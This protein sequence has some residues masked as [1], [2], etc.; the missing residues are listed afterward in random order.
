MDGQLIF[1]EKEFLDGNIF[2]FEQRLHSHVNKYIQGGAILS[3]YFSQQG[4]ATTV[5]RGTRDI[6]QLFGKQSPLR[7]SKIS[8]FPLYAFGPTNPDNTD[9]NQIEDITV[10]GDFI[11]LP[12]TTVPNVFDFFILNHLKMTA[13]FQ[14][15][16]VT[17]DSMKI[18][19]FYKIRY[20]LISTEDETIQKLNN[21]VVEKY[22]VDLNAVGSNLN[23]VIQEDEFIHKKQVQQMVSQM[24][25]SYRALYYNERHNCFL[26]HHPDMGLDWFDLCGNEFM[27]KHSIMNN[28]NSTKVI[29]LNSKIRDIQLS[30]FYNNSIY[31]WLELGAPARML[32]NFHFILNYADGYPY[33]SFVKWNDGDIQVMQPL[34][35]HQVGVNFREYSFF[36]ADQLAAFIDVNHEPTSYYEKLIW[37]YIHYPNQLK[38]TDVSL[39][40]ADSLISSI[41]HI[42]TFLYTPIVIYIIR[43]I[44]GMN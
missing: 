35:L 36:D 8:N 16:S 11:V 17:Y 1:S 23:P 43:A 38:I 2:Q 15:T 24:I 4:N 3:T 32:Q 21:Q 5:D 20:R 9:E 10:E 39:Y 22:S 14:V 25:M 26:Y 6:D 41:R 37:K 31:N 44:L 18:D 40:T 33:S 42:D 29:I 19:G 12:S 30:L 28:E 13:L 34:G 7:F 27:A